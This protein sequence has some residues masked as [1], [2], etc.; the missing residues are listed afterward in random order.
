M[1]IESS[2]NVSDILAAILALSAQ[3][4]QRLASHLFARREPAAVALAHVIVARSVR[5][6]PE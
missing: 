6:N 5:D 3:D 1:E 4:Q 2:M